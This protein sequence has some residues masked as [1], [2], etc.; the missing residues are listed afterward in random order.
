MLK[1]EITIKRSP[2]IVWAYFTEPGNWE[3]WWG[4]GLKSAQWRKGGKLEWALGGSS[5]IQ[6]ITPG[7]MVQ[8]S[9]SWADTTFTFEP[10]GSGKTMVR[11]QESSPKGGASF[12]DGG[13]AHLASLNSYLNKLKEHIESEAKQDRGGDMSTAEYICPH[14]GS[15]LQGFAL[16]TVKVSMQTGVVDFQTICSSCG[17]DITQ[18]DI[19]SSSK[20]GV[21]QSAAEKRPVASPTKKWWEFWK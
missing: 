3:N 19:E 1:A 6:A 10:N 14:C 7:R 12:S 16:T 20:K 21:K 4:G 2:E 13:A 5:P 18:R 8:T 11:I 15:E 17:R 9:G